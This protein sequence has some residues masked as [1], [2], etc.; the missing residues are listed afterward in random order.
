MRSSLPDS[1]SASRKSEQAFDQA[2]AF[3]DECEAHRRRREKEA[4]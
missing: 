4:A 2:K 3:V 1:A